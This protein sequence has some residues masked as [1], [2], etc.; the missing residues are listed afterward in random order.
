MKEIIIRV[1][2]IAG[3]LFLGLSAIYYK[4]KNVELHDKVEFYE[5]VITD[6]GIEEFINYPELY[7]EDGY[8]DQVKVHQCMWAIQEN[9]EE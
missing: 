4:L 3:I 8:I 9:C 5:K 6:F 2:I 7:Y 1:I